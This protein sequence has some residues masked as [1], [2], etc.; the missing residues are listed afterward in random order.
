MFKINVSLSYY[1]G[2]FTVADIFP[3]DPK[4]KM[5]VPLPWT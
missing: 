4:N 1:C 5:E 2:G 3:V